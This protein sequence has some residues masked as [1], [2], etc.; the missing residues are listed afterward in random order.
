MMERGSGERKKK[1]I[2]KQL[3]KLV[4]ESLMALPFFHV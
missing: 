2:E 3:V 4:K 1:Q